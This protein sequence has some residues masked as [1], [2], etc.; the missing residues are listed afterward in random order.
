MYKRQTVDNLAALRVA[1]IR[2]IIPEEEDL[3]HYNL[4]NQAATR[5]KLTENI[6]FPTKRASKA[7]ISL[8]IVHL[9]S[10]MLT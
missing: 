7:R 6:E 10:L 5:T 8:A 4:R 3:L 1:F 9:T 2:V